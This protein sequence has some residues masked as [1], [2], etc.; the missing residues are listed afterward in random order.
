MAIRA[1]VIDGIHHRHSVDVNVHGAC[2][3]TH[4]VSTDNNQDFLLYAMVSQH[5]QSYDHY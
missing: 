4:H 5:R 1:A 2:N 3:P